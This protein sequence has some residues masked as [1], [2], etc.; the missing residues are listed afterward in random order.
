[1]LQIALLN[2]E[3]Y[4]PAP[5]YN[6]NPSHHHFTPV[7]LQQAVTSLVLHSPLPVNLLNYITFLYQTIQGLSTAHKTNC[8]FSPCKTLFPVQPY[9]C[10]TLWFQS[11]PPLCPSL[12][13]SHTTSLLFLRTLFLFL[14]HGIATCCP[15]HQK[16][17]S[18]KSS[19]SSLYLIIQV[20]IQASAPQRLHT[21]G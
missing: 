19:P 8:K 10:Q 21:L 17:S 20:S 2:T 16:C 9:L 4:L 3:L 7:L 6:P 1:M 14:S 11:S 15:L 18:L 5:S 13:S 12:Y